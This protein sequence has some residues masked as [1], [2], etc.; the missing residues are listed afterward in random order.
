MIPLISYICLTFYPPPES[1][2]SN[3]PWHEQRIEY[4]ETEPSIEEI[5]REIERRRKIE[6][7]RVIEIYPED[8]PQ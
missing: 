2:L 7:Y 5:E 4:I 8:A 3:H 6:Q 1:V